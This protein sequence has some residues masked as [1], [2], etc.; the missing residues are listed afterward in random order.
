[1]LD[2]YKLGPPRIPVIGSLISVLLT[3]SKSP[4]D[5]FRKLSEKYGPI[6]TLQMGSVLTGPYK[7]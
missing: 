1:M 4:A 7:S 3:D 5:A 6:F 2:L